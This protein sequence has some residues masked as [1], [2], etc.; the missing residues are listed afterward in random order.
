MSAV[1]FSMF[2]LVEDRPLTPPVAFTT[3]VLVRTPTLLFHAS[4]SVMVTDIPCSSE[5]APRKYN[6]DTSSN[7]LTI[8]QDPIAPDIDSKLCSKNLEYV[9]FVAKDTKV[10]GQR[11]GK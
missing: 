2:T 6:C 4:H 3:I 5:C 8:L 1:I 10:F 11:R 9:Q 7:S